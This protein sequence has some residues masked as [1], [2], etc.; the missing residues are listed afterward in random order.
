MACTPDRERQR[1]LRERRRR[2]Q[3]VAKVRVD[4]I[5][6]KK[7]AA[8][9]YLPS[10][11]VLAEK[12]SELDSGARIS[13]AAAPTARSRVLQNAS[14]PSAEKP[15]CAIR[16][17]QYGQPASPQPASVPVKRMRHRATQSL[18]VGSPAGEKNPTG[19]PAAAGPS[20]FE[21]FREL[22][23]RNHID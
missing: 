2:G 12:G 22:L 14:T 1:R 3:S 7:L 10:A 6:M 11:F 4:R 21:D 18:G 17:P 16:I 19:I 23:S 5:E 13:P 15:R 20:W 8:L 9:G